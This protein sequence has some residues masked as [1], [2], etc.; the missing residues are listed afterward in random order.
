MPDT[1]L[2]VR[3]TLAP[4]ELLARHPHETRAYLRLVDLYRRARFGAHPTGRAEATGAHRGSGQRS[5]PP[6]ARLMDG[7]R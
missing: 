1:V 2:P 4:P 7:R 5:F 3:E 6:T